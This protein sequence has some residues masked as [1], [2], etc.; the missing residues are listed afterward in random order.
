MRTSNR[1]GEFS[2]RVTAKCRNQAA[3]PSIQKHSI[4]EAVEKQKIAYL[5]KQKSNSFL[6]VHQAGSR[7]PVL[8]I[9]CDGHVYSGW[10]LASS[11]R[12][13]TFGAGARQ[14]GK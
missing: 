14:K 4:L 2:E 3:F 8:E 13:Q 12:A 11:D 6:L 10:L 5:Q 7:D 9:P 1:P